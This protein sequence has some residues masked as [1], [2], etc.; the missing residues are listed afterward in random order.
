MKVL[1]VLIVVTSVKFCVSIPVL[2][3]GF[4]SE[5]KYNNYEELTSL[6]HQ[7]AANYPNLTRLHSIGKSVQNRD[8]WAIEINKG[9]G[10]RNLL[11]PMFKYVANMHGDEAV[12]RQ[13][14]IYLAQYLLINYGNDN[15]ITKLVD[16]T[17]IFL[18]PSMNPDGFEAS[19]EG[20]CESKSDFSGRQNANNIDLN[21]DFPDQFDPVVKS[22]S[23]IKDKQ[24]ETVALMSWIVSQPF[25]LS[26]NLH[27]GSVVASYPYDDADGNVTCCVESLTPDNSLFKSLASVYAKA[28]PLMH[29]GTACPDDT[30]HD[31]TTNG[32]YWYDVHGGMQDF[33]YLHSNCFEITFEL[34]CCKY[35]YA[36]TLRDEWQRN[37]ESLLSFIE[38]SHW[39]V[40]GLV[41]DEDGTP[42]VRAD[43]VVKGVGH[44]VTT[45][46]KGEYWRLLVPG[47]YEI[48]VVAYGFLP[49]EVATVKVGQN[50]ATLQNFKLKREVSQAGNYQNL[51]NISSPLTDEYGFVMK[52]EFKHHNYKEL[53]KFLQ[54]MNETYPNI[55]FLKSVGQ[56][57]QGRELYVMTVSST[58]FEHVPGKPEFK[59]V[60]NMHGN[61]VVGRELLLLLIKYLCE[62]YGTDQR[63]TKMLDTTRIHI[64]PSMNPDGYEMAHEGDLSSGVGRANAH[65]VDLNRNFPDRLGVNEY[66]RITEPETKAVMKWILS[67]P[68]VLSANL[69]N[70]ALVANYPFDDGRWGKASPSPDDAVFRYL[71][72]VYSNAHRTM[73]NGVACPQFPKEHFKEG[74]TNGNEW[75]T[76]TGG[77]QDWNYVFAGC[78][79]ITLEL[80][81]DKFPYASTLPQYWMDNREALL[82]YIEQVHKGVK[83]FV[84]STIG[85]PIPNAEI[86]VEGIDF[87]VRSAK[88]GDY[89]R[90]LLPGKYNLTVSAKGFETFTQ[91]IVIPPS[92]SLH[93]KISLMR[94]DPL[95]W[96][97]A[98]DFGIQENQYNP[99]YH[100]NNE[101]YAVMADLE[102]KYPSS[103]SFDAGDN[104][105]SMSIRSL[106]ITD[107]IETSDETKYRLAII[108]NLYATQP[109]GR[110]LSLNMARHLLQGYHYQDPTIV[111]I[112]ENSVI[113]VVP[114]IDKEFEKIWGEYLKF[115]VGGVEP[116]TEVCNNITA[117]FRQVGDQI[118]KMGN[119]ANKIQQTANAFK[120]LLL[121][122][123]FDLVLN[124]EGGR[125]GITYPTS[126]QP[127]DLFKKFAEKFV[128]ALK[129]K[130][131]CNRV[132]TGT[133]AVLTDF[134]YNEY[135][136]P[137]F[138]ANVDCCE[139]PAVENIPYIWR[140]TVDPVMAFLANI[141]TGIQGYVLDR[142]QK[143]MHNATVKVEGLRKMFEVTKNLAHFKI[144][145]PPGQYRVEVSCHNYQT[146]HIDVSVNENSLLFVRVVL[147]EIS[148]SADRD[149]DKQQG[150]EHR[151]QQQVVAEGESHEPLD[152]G[153]EST[154]IIGYVRDS[155]NRPI[156]KAELTIVETNTTVY[157]DGNGKYSV[158]LQP[159]KYTVKV[160]ASGYLPNVKYTEL[161]PLEL[162]LP[163]KMLMISMER[164][165]TVAG[166]PRLAFIIIAGMAGLF[167]MGVV[168]VCYTMC[169]NR[170][171]KEYGLLS[172]EMYDDFRDMDETK[173]TD[174][175]TAPFKDATKFITRPYYDNDDDETESDSERSDE[176]VLMQMEKYQKVPSKST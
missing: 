82:T 65:G 64:M 3:E 108:G 27:G 96:A 76:V 155:L 153:L 50:G 132:V 5:E 99:R 86:R 163:P 106:K 94:D 26:G 72:S 158:T 78:M 16:S 148:D 129:S 42:I 25:V 156:A 59:F 40:K 30:F 13:L 4:L 58:P 133:D 74:I 38:S 24:P 101:I 174:L 61:E 48:Y 93:L 173:E 23:L 111:H 28:N 80:G 170:R 12:G 159:G 69:H 17:D 73:H 63:V 32:A 138:T 83:G 115:D 109:L 34:S 152:K 36:N 88:D 169:K 35:P 172:Q 100:F 22:G 124:I 136:V 7:L 118:L 131:D 134:I 97:S 168:F 123:R 89:W 117:D 107:K 103:A 160:Q 10:K 84:S 161:P 52:P 70:G 19:E 21:R 154:G 47:E 67:E 55:T 128:N 114:V 102:N 164:D 54:E 112:L 49:S 144:M 45:S 57:V 135:D 41:T 60:A 122:E 147:N 79:E 162:N 105:V 90:I 87:V 171:D 33:N 116:E 140:R 14:M 11:T 175:F 130:K 39:G 141:R 44:N 53:E 9:A 51:K 37:K 127:L 8:L 15:R 95:H 157:T 56:S 66:N 20:K 68:F 43:V 71:A 6:F 2:N 145:L 149:H 142:S 151:K 150:Q 1:I 113:Y 46:N 176:I 81:C 125:L 119:R 165:T 18:M 139:Y 143:P 120:H 92:G 166:L 85:H 75:Y 91:E 62:N 104:F 110:E 121:E 126:N 167:I 98:Y 29:S 77:M 146:S 137:V 31:G